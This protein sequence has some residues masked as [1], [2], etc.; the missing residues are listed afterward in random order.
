MKRNNRC[1]CC[2]QKMNIKA[3]I[4]AINYYEKENDKM[5]KSNM[6]LAKINA[7]LKLKC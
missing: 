7:K 6:E 4:H 1:P 5:R 2:D 3:I